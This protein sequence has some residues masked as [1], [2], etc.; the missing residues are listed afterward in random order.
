MTK[1]TFWIY[2]KHP[3]HKA[4]KNNSR[5]K[6][7]LI[8]TKSSQNDMNLK[9]LK[10]PY[11]VVDNNT[12]NKYLDRAD[13]VH[14]GIALLVEA[15]SKLSAKEYLSNSNKQKDIVIALDQITD[16]QNVG[17]IVRSA[18]AFNACSLLTTKDNSFTESATLA[19]SSSGYI[20]N[21]NII[22]ENNLS[23]ALEKFKKHGYWIVGL[24]GSS[25]CLI[26]DAAKFDKVVLVLGAEGKG[27]RR[28][29]KENCDLLCKIKMSDAVDSLNVSNAA[30]I[31]LYE[32]GRSND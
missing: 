26:S 15:K 18:V 30:A 4:L 21:I 31:T 28:L 13:A 1:S 22:E 17:A 24:D 16:P 7:K 11:E 2:G 27:M 10:I 12:I 20:E 14:Q 25:N 9:A 6:V 29:T 23:S 5:I 19:K 3:V 8:L 32:L